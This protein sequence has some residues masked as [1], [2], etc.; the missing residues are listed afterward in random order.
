ML[1]DKEDIA[2]IDAFLMY[3]T[4]GIHEMLKDRKVRPQNRGGIK[5]GRGGLMSTR[6]LNDSCH[7]LAASSYGSSI[8]VFTML[9][10]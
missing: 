4:D 6:F 5:G 3:N 10:M 9:D 1:I 2:K 7:S 8:M